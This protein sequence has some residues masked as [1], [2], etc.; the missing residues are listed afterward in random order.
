[1]EENFITR[2]FG[3]EYLSWFA[4][5]LPALASAGGP[6]PLGGTSMHVRRDALE[7]RAGISRK[8]GRRDTRVSRDGRR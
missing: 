7:R 3:A 5:M 2:S 8:A 1:M 6:V 4:F